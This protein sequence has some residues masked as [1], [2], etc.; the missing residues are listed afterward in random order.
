MTGERSGVSS[1]AGSADV[2][3]DP[4]ATAEAAATAAPS[5]AT[6][7]PSALRGQLVRFAI[8]GTFSTLLSVLLFAGFA[9]FTSHQWANALSLVL[10]TVA[11]TAVN[12][13]FT[14]GV[15][16]G[17]QGKAQLLSLGLLAMTIAVTAGALKLLEVLQPGADTLAAV[18]AFVIG[19]GIATIIR[20]LLLRKVF[21]QPD[22]G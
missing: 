16:G 4:D 3:T 9:Q 10:S 13:R 19:N 20:F 15:S 8:V 18:V 7:A 6:P 2:P 21:G 1:S 14:F 17:G 12:R 11:N 22:P 5:S